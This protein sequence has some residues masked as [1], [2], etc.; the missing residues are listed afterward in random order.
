M[1]N[2][3]NFRE[4]LIQ[5]YSSFSRS[6]ARI[7]AADIRETV[8]REYDKGR[9]WPEPLIQINPNYRRGNTVQQ[10]VEEGLLHRACAEI[11]QIDKAAGRPQPLQLYTHQEQ[12]LA[13]GQQRQSYVVTTGTGSGKSLSFFI[14]VIDSILKGKETD[15]DGTQRTRAIVIYPMNALANS[16]LEELHKFLYG[17]AADQQPFTVARYTG[18]ESSAERKNIADNPPDILLT[19][20]M[21]LELILTRFDED[22]RRV[23]DHCHGLEFLILDELHTYRGRQGADVAL[24]V[25]RLR[26]RLQAHNLVCIGTSATMSSMNAQADRNNT[27]A[28][29]ASKLF[30]T[31]I[32]GHD[33]IGETLERVTDPLKDAA[34]IQAALPAAIRREHHTWADFPSFQA[35]PL[36]IWVELNLGIELRENEPPRRAQ[37]MNV[38]TASE[39][40]AADSDCSVEESRNALQR[41]LIAAHEINTPQGRPPFAFK[42]HQ[43]ISCPGKVLTTLEAP[44]TR[45]VTLDA[46]RS[47]LRPRPASGRGGT[48]SGPFLPGLWSGIPS[49]LAFQK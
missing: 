3:F 1:E 44:G 34:A 31:R 45:H 22:D 16:Q 18:Q 5:E 14:P 30:G 35:D 19:N 37:P 43:F 17:Y 36:A 12:A 8:Q 48:L 47:T 13:K 11:F 38:K 33:V 6:F 2:V 39:K 49:G 29:V 26:E 27:V 41:F 15:G 32:S 23:V 40:L 25:R 9:Y 20:F 46:Q 42:L 21:M 7:D 28:D 24:L 4:Q 10:L